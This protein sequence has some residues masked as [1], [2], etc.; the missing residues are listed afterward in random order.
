MMEIRNKK[1]AIKVGSKIIASNKWSYNI[2]I[3]FCIVFCGLQPTIS[4][5]IVNGIVKNVIT[6]PLKCIEFLFL[7]CMIGIFLK[8]LI[9]VMKKF[10][11][12]S[13]EKIGCNTNLFF[14]NSL[15]DITGEYFEDEKYQ[16][17]LALLRDNKYVIYDIFDMSLTIVQALI[18]IISFIIYIWSLNYLLSFFYII[19]LII[20]SIFMAKRGEKRY[21]ASISV[22]DKSRTISHASTI[23]TTPDYAKELRIFKYKN[24]ILNKWKTLSEEVQ[25]ELYKIDAINITLVKVNQ[26]I[27]YLFITIIFILAG[28]EI[29]RSKL[30]SSIIVGLIS[31]VTGLEYALAN[32][33]SNIEQVNSNLNKV[34][35]IYS[36]FYND[37][38]KNQNIQ[39]IEMKDD[40]LVQME[41]VCFRYPS[42]NHEILRNV[43]LTIKVG[44]KI[45]I[46]GENGAGKSTLAK[47]IA[48]IYQPTNGQIKYYI[49]NA[50]KQK[51]TDLIG[52][53]P[54]N[55]EKYQ[56]TLKE[57]ICL[58]KEIND[59]EYE[60]ILHEF[61]LNRIRDNFNNGDNEIIG[62]I[63]GNT[64]LSGGEWQKVAMA[65][66]M[67][68][69]T[70]KMYILDEP[71]S[72][73]DAKMESN[74]FKDFNKN[75]KERATII[76]S[77]RL[78]SIKD[79]DRIILIKNGQITECGNHDELMNL[80]GNYYEMYNTQTQWYQ[81]ESENVQE[82]YS[83]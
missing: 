48:G 31:M 1:A 26:L 54:Q 37:K 19:F 59:K 77:H 41:N 18:L 3:I 75:S 72:A 53:M 40:N 32:L 25:G 71:T 83:E 73:L 49:N 81:R 46:V 74:L 78:G 43:N 7:E 27:S 57:N 5:Y 16:K 62:K 23:M 51:I 70:K 4:A 30:D 28:I 67:G 24:Y 36:F 9:I 45:A 14:L 65:R 8:L 33:G 12:L 42:N 60:N 2:V 21:Q 11:Q 20:F 82:K 50:N 34:N 63:F 39:I 79:A 29:W 52:M 55:F 13:R 80:K 69:K 35:D 47:L 64:D 61:E 17:K 15:K 76:I 56:I 38:Y 10:Q 58:G 22:M 66:C 68:V 44:E 6:D